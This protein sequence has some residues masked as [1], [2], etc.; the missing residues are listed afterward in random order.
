MR[1]I[2]D[3]RMILNSMTGVSRYL[4]GLCRGLDKLDDDCSYE[5]WLQ[6]NLPADHPA[7]KLGGNRL[8]LHNVSIP[9][10]SLAGHALL[11]CEFARQKADLIHYPHFDLPL[12]MPGPVVSTIH[13]LKYIA[14]PDFFPHLDLVKRKVIH[15]MTRYTCYRSRQILCDS[16]STSDD[17]QN[18][19]GISR[20]KLKIVHLGVD[21]HFFRKISKNE[22]LDFR[23]KHN[24]EQPFLLFVGER[25]PHKNL[26]TLIRAFK[27]FESLNNEGFLLVVAGKSYADNRAPEQLTSKL[28]LDGRVR[29][30]DYVP[31]AELPYYYQS[32]AALVLLS[33]YEGF[34]FPVL[35]AM[36]SGTPVVAS[37]CTSLPEVV[38]EAGI[39]VPPDKP[40]RAAEAILEV[41]SPGSVRDRCIEKGEE[42]ARSFSWERCASLTQ[43]VYAEAVKN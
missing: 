20:E 38:G 27:E 29:F 3:G 42:R 12:V 13:D 43:Q 30:L 14:H 9:N 2:I 32:A 5:L 11:P 23:I 24:L 15:L 7:K 25:R 35:E 10:M 36:A 21:D 8:K 37:S 18:L 6:E 33:Y 4:I 22:L 19:L 34:G 1:I 16:K 39:L 17:L 31:D 28:G 40:K 26:P 41:V